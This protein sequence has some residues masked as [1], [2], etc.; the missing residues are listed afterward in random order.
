MFLLGEQLILS[1]DCLKLLLD[2]KIKN[3]L[4]TLSEKEVGTMATIT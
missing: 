4:V 2:R 3:I 1:W